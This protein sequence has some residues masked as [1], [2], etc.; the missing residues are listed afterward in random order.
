MYFILHILCLGINTPKL[1]GMLGT[2]ISLFDTSPPTA[3]G[4]YLEY[5][6]KRTFLLYKS[7]PLLAAKAD[8]TTPCVPEPLISLCFNRTWAN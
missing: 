2:C 6:S 4:N 8:P 5:L 3:A 7:S 1:P